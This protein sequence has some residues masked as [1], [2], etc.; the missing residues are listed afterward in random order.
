[1]SFS[2][3]REILSYAAKN[4]GAHVFESR[5]FLDS[6]RRALD[7]SGKWH[8]RECPLNAQFMM[9]FVF[10]L[11]LYRSLS[12]ANVLK[13]I[14]RKFRSKFPSLSLRA[15]TPEAVCH[16][17]DRLT[18]EPLRIF[19]ETQAAQIKPASLFHGLAVW[20]VD[21]SSF[22]VPDTP[23]NAACFGRPTAKPR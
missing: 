11:L 23:A 16:A 12:I 4:L 3:L 9:R 5:D 1:M 22:N 7:E 20:A 15:I 13:T 8:R 17:K 21:G 6:A 18:S 2:N 19:F 10:A 14:L